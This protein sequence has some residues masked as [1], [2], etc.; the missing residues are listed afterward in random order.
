MPP[1]Y[2][3]LLPRARAV[4]I[5]LTLAALALCVHPSRARARP[6]ITRY[7]LHPTIVLD[8]V[9]QSPTSALATVR[10]TLTDDAQASPPLFHVPHRAPPV[11]PRQRAGDGRSTRS[12]VPPR[13]HNRR[14]RGARPAHSD[15]DDDGEDNDN[16][17]D[18][19]DNDDNDDDDDDELEVWKPAPC[20][21]TTP[22]RHL[23]L[24]VALDSALCARY[25]GSA[26]HTVAAALAALEIAGRAY[27]TQVC[28]RFVATYVDLHCD[29]TKDP[30]VAL[31]DLHSQEDSFAMLNELEQ[32]WRVSTRLRAVQRDAVLFLP[33]FE[34][35]SYWGQGNIGITCDGDGF[36]WAQELRVRTIAH[37]LGH[38][39]GAA[40]SPTGV[41]RDGA[42]RDTVAN[43]LDW[44]SVVE[45]DSYLRFDPAAHCIQVPNVTA[46]SSS[47]SPSASVSASVSASPAPHVAQSCASAFTPRLGLACASSE[48][49]LHFWVG[50]LRLDIEQRNGKVKATVQAPPSTRSDTGTTVTLQIRAIHLHLAS[51]SALTRS[52]LPGVATQLAF[53]DSDSGAH[54]WDMRSVR[55]PD[56]S[57]TCCDRVLFVYAYVRVRRVTTTAGGVVVRDKDEKF[58]KFPWVVQCA[59]CGGMLLKAEA[60]R[61]CPVCRY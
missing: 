9:R 56:G 18:N 23:Q 51:T 7:E 24:A 49:E 55:F 12:D 57:D 37:E 8:G 4:A 20:N 41:M 54:T 10:F 30:Y 46:V 19:D 15:V 60:V 34:H 3:P 40:H 61:P 53:A 16:D 25:N 38:L 13:G 5:A 21:A 26:A 1:H 36:A 22:R 31:R 29:E 42:D 32:L 44:K 27:D 33:G 43:V 17:N 11:H 2:P 59:S 58:Q 48:N 39:L 14:P 47:P 6:H 35:V 52:D 50:V 28:V 45:I